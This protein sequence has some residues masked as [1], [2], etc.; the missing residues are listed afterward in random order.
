MS[1][2]LRKI[3]YALALPNTLPDG[4]YAKSSEEFICFSQWSN[5]FTSV[6]AQ[7]G[8]RTFYFFIGIWACAK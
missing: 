1:S 2:S 5:M 6:L 8:S 7:F 3:N 4:C